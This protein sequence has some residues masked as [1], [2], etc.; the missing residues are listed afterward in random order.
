MT[1]YE[2]FYVHYEKYR[3]KLS[4]ACGTIKSAM[5]SAIRSK[6]AVRLVDHN[7]LWGAIRTEFEVKIENRRSIWDAAA[8]SYGVDCGTVVMSL[9]YA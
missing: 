6:F 8:C 2:R 3:E 5:E 7:G 9:R 4:K 1:R